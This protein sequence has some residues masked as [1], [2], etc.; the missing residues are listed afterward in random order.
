MLCVYIFLTHGKFVNTSNP[1]E[2]Q[3]YGA[4]TIVCLR[5]LVSIPALNVACNLIEQ[6]VYAITLFS[7]YVLPHSQ[8]HLYM[9]LMEFLQSKFSGGKDFCD[10]W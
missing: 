2:S 4:I 9:L 7:V 5:G 8:Q 1:F 6:T 3:E 10:Y